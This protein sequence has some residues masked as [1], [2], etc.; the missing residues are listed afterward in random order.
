MNEVILNHI[1]GDMHVTWT[2]KDSITPHAKRLGYKYVVMTLY[3]NIK[4]GKV[5]YE[6]RFYTKK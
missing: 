4:T 2:K 1:N 6:G 3:V 5:M